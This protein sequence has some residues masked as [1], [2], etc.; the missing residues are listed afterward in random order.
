MG[1]WGSGA[2]KAWLLHESLRDINAGA[3]ALYFRENQYVG[4]EMSL[5]LGADVVL[6]FAGH[7][8]GVK[9]MFKLFHILQ[10]CFI[11]RVYITV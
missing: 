8:T 3:T 1:I 5:F 4:F 6:G 9:Q 7:V 10:F 11:G 2:V